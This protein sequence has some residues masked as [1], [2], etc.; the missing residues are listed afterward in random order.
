MHHPVAIEVDSYR[1]LAIANDPGWRTWFNLNDP[2]GYPI[3]LGLTFSTLHSYA[4]ILFLQVIL[5]T[6]TTLIIW[7]LGRSLLTPKWNRVSS[8][9]RRTD[10]ILSGGSNIYPAEIESVLM[11]HPSV[12]TAIVIGLPDEDL[13]AVPHAI[14][15]LEKDV[16]Q[17]AIEELR[18]FAATRLLHYK[19]PRTFEFT[20]DQLRDEAGKVRRS[21][22]RAERVGRMQSPQ[23]G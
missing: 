12:E 13:G 14:L 5:S 7:D 9:F 1:Y 22:L 8:L 11:E 10:M 23:P 6:L 16:E 3:L 4:G 19:V 18:D 20:E 2:A 15:R 21:R 17:P